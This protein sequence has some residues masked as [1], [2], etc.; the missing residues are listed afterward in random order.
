MRPTS[1]ALVLILLAL[2]AGCGS[3]SVFDRNQPDPIGTWH[4]AAVNAH[5][6]PY[7]ARISGTDTTVIVSSRIVLSSDGRWS[8]TD[9][10]S[11]RTGTGAA[12]AVFADDGTWSR[13]PA[14]VSLQSA[15]KGAF[16]LAFQGAALF[17][18]APMADITILLDVSYTRPPH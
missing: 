12:S 11:H 8:K 3:S 9:S 2:P 13:S 14:G 6:L 15:T 10:V 17:G 5:A 16:E 7:V 1:S 4:L 18:F